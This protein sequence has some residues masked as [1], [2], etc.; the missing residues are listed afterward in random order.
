[1]TPKFRLKITPGIQAAALTPVGPVRV[2][3]GYNPYDRLK[4]PLYYENTASAG[5]TLPCVTRG[6]NLLVTPSPTDPMQLEQAPGVCLASFQPSRRTS[7]RSRLTF[8][9]AIGQAF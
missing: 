6:N 2:I 9:L 5:G 8:S 7:F 1:L 3:V 4:G